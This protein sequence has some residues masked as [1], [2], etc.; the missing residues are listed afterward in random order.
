MRF[1]GG[2]IGSQRPPC[3]GPL[4]RKICDLS[5]AVDGRKERFG[6]EFDEFLG[7]CH[8]CHNWFHRRVMNAQKATSYDEEE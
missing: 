5:P 8:E 2:E 6:I 3:R 1:D 7:C 4:S